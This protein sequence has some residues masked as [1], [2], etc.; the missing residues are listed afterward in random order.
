MTEAHIIYHNYNK[1][2]KKTSKCSGGHIENT[3][4]RVLSDF[5]S[6][7]IQYI[8]T[9]TF[10][11]KVDFMI[12]ITHLLFLLMLVWEMFSFWFYFFFY[13][14]MP[15]IFPFSSGFWVCGKVGGKLCN[16][17]LD[18]KISDEWKSKRSVGSAT[19]G[20]TSR[21]WCLL[22]LAKS[23][24]VHN[25]GPVNFVI[26]CIL[27]RFSG[28]LPS[29]ENGTLWEDPLFLRLEF[30]S[31]ENIKMKEFG[32]NYTSYITRVCV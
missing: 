17:P 13:I 3:L 19:L 21:S 16:A 26:Q 7:V 1:N 14:T 2:I 6:F 22:W 30:R 25:K 29:R 5:L 4:G 10:I 28:F 20:S 18:Q 31:S 9:G 15:F 23:S 11:L 27:T 32:K 24:W 12:G 8:K